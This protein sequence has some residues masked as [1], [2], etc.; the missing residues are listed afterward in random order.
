MHFFEATPLGRI[1]NRFSSDVGII[2]DSLPFLLN[3]LLAILFSLLGSLVVTCFAMP[4][5]LVICLPLLFVYWSVQRVYRNA[6]RD[7]KR[8]SRLLFWSKFFCISSATIFV[9]P[10]PCIM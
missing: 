1:L 5:I 2:D 10:H 4:G 9:L 7:L 3:I 6:A 8:L